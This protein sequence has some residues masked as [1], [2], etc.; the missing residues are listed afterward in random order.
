M[1]KVMLMKRNGLM[2]IILITIKHDDDAGDF[3][4]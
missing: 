3:G 2:L 1:M 4:R